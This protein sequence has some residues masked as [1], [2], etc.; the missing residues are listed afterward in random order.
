MLDD[1]PKEL[2]LRD[3]ENALIRVATRDDEL[4]LALFF[5][6]I[7]EDQRDFLPYDLSEQESLQ[8]W[9]GGP[10]WE[11]AFP[12]VAEVDSRIVAVSLLKTFRV[13]WYSHVGEAWMLVHENMRGLG[14]GHIMGTELNS[15]AHDLGI[16]KLKTQVRADSPEAVKVL[17]QLGFEHEGIL[18]DYIKDS[19]G[20]LHDLAI[21]SCNT[22]DLPQPVQKQSETSE[23]DQSPSLGYSV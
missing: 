20:Q 11:D 6:S 9:F 18:T 8:G 1:Y 17:R 13:P 21:L 14:L 19:Q 3:G 15:L 2:E 5:V 22:S 16:E 12:L 7:P 23:P 10:N 4:R